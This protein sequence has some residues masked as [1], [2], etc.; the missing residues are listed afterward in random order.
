MLE[1][2]NGLARTFEQVE[3]QT[4]DGWHLLAPLMTEDIEATH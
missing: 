1:Q 2:G 4:Q 3:R